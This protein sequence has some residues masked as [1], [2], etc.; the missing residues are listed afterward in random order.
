MFRLTADLGS[1]ADP[2]S[3]NLE[4]VD[5][6]TFEKIGTGMSLSSGVYT[7]PSTGL[8]HVIMNT[9]HVESSADFNT[10]YMYVSSDSGSAYDA[11]A[12]NDTY[13]SV[14]QTM[15]KNAFV[16]VTDASTFRVK[17]VTSSFTNATL[18]GETNMNYTNFTFIRLGDS[19]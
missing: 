19:Q 18:K 4:R 14:Q 5:D 11:V 15:S 16:N 13:S 8:Y 17:F 2:I 6:A 12:S 10:V 1:N 3:S 7:F 9:Y